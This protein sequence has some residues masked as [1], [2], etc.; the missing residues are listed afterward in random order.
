VQ[1]E[2]AQLNAEVDRPDLVVILEADPGSCPNGLTSQVRNRFQV[3]SGSS[4]AEAAG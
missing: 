1:T 4:H 2:I 3:T